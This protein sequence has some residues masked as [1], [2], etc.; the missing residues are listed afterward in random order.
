MTQSFATKLEVKLENFP[1][2]KTTMAD[3]LDNGNRLD[4]LVGG[5]F[6]TT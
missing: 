5:L 2:N 6:A 3:S 1:Y 4:L